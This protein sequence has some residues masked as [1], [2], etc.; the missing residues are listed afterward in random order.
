MS[1]FLRIGFG[2]LIVAVIV[3]IFRPH[4]PKHYDLVP[5]WETASADDNATLY[6]TDFSERDRSVREGFTHRGVAA[7]IPCTDANVRGPHGESPR[8]VIS[9]NFGYSVPMNFGCAE[10]KKSAPLY[11]YSRGALQ[12]D[13]AYATSAAEADALVKD[14]YAFERVDGYVFVAQVAGSVP[15]YRLSRCGS[16]D[17]RCAPQHRYSISS[18]TRDSLLAAGWHSDGIVGYVFDSYTNRYAY[19]EF[20]GTLNGIAG[21]GTTPV[22]IPLQD[23]V[24]PKEAIALG[25]NGRHHVLGAFSSN[26]T[27]RPVGADRQ[28]ITFSLYTGDLFDNGKTNIDHI[29]IWLYGHAQIAS[30][31][32]GGVPYD[33]LGIFFSLPQWAG[34]RCASKYTT[35]GQ[36]F[37]E[38]M[39]KVKIDCAANLSKPLEAKRWYDVSLTVTD[40]AELSYAVKDRETNEVFSFSKDYAGDYACPITHA[41]GS[42]PLSKLY[43]NNPFSY[44]RFP[45]ARTGYFIWPIFNGVPEARGQLANVV[46]QWLDKDNRVVSVH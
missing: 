6:T 1:T 45:E 31:G 28:R 24:A 40:R 2:L 43:C 32:E 39:S 4:K 36:I 30:D 18:D 21:D 37:V 16:D 5:L 44:D 8:T 46:V 33:G 10:P 38:Q 41:P 34:N 19:A 11:R 9:S 13:R 42:L 27:E 3:A 20:S 15:F 17:R 26:S 7:W 14:G 29:P 12:A 23:V 25:G 22:R 35:G